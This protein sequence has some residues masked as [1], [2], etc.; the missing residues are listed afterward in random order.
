MSRHAYSVGILTELLP[1]EHPNLL[2]LNENMGARISL[3]IRTDR[4]DGFRDYTTSRRVL[5]HELAH[6]EVNDHPPEFKELNSQLNNELARFERDQREGARHLTDAE[7]YDPGSS[8]GSELGM[9]GQT[10]EEEQREEMRLRILNATEK[11]LAEQDAEIEVGCGNGGPHVA[12]KS[13]TKTT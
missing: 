8:R 9:F 2:G 10:R 13:S 11:R 5:M 3:R 12:A 4:Y 7:T 1:H 6:N